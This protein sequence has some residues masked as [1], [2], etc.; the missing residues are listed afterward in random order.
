MTFKRRAKLRLA[1]V[2]L[3]AAM[4]FAAPRAG[5]CEVHGATA[6]DTLGLRDRLP[7]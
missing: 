4:F 7:P 3:Y 2:V 6:T 5:Q 1:V